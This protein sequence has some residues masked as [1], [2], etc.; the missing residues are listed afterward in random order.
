MATARVSAGTYSTRTAVPDSIVVIAS[1]MS[2]QAKRIRP[3]EWA[4]VSAIEQT[5][6]IIAG[7][8]PFV[9]RASSSR[10]RSMSRSGSCSTLRRVEVEDVDAV[11][12]RRRPKPDVTAHAPG[13]DERGVEAFLGTFV[14]PMK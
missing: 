12:L 10:R 11:V 4:N 8:E 2:C 3:S 14:A 7:E 9:I 1:T 13:P 6:S 5:C